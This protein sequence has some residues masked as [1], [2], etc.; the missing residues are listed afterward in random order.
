MT[1]KEIY[2]FIDSFAPF[3][4]QEAFDNA[5]LLVG[6][7][8]TPVTGVMFAMDVTDRVLDE[9]MAKGANLIVSHH[10][11]MFSARKNMT[12]T[13]CEGRLLCRMIREH[14]ALIAAHTNLDRAPGGINDVLA[15]VCGLTDV[16][17]SDFIRVGELP[18][19]TTTESLLKALSVG[20]NTTIRVMGQMPADRQLHRMVVGGGS[21]SDFWADAVA[22]GADVFLTGEM[23]HHHALALADAGV[24][25]LEAGHF[26][27][28]EPGI[29]ALANALQKH[30]VDVQCKVSIYKSQSGAYAM[31]VDC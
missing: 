21:A 8:D 25:A 15:Q 16:R 17:G 28:E 7:T 11:M 19:G 24:L 26:A 23:K 5:G 13:D 31:P 9:A 30:F 12:E 29:F 27:T 22:E 20:L 14:M 3:A 6:A 2:S 4:S 1:V 10:P 18:A